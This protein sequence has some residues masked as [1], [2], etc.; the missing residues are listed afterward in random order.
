MP[1]Y[2]PEVTG[3]IY[4][5]EEC[6]LGSILIESTRGTNEAIREVSKLV[7]PGDFLGCMISDPPDRWTWRA[8]MYYAMLQ[9]ELPP[10]TV[11]VAKKMVELEILHDKDLSLMAHCVA[12]VPCSL[13][14]LHYARAVKDYSLQRKVKYHAAKGN[15]KRLNELTS[16]IKFMGGVEGL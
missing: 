8:R 7:E 16:N 1:N 6:L 12:V 15:F 14:Y 4:D 13:D 3:A 2:Q 9:C 5:S 11:N 10:H